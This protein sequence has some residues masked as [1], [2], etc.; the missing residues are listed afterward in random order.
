[1]PIIKQ[2]QQ[3]DIIAIEVLLFCNSMHSDLIQYVAWQLFAKIQLL[4]KL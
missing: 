2:S 3:V 4:E 1:M